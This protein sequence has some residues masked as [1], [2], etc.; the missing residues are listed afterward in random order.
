MSLN[1]NPSVVIDGLVMYYDMSNTQKSWKGA[2]TTNLA[3]AYAGFGSG[4]ETQPAVFNG[5]PIYRNT[6]TTPSVG[7]NFGFTQQTSVALN[8]SGPKYITLSFWVNVL[9]S[10][11]AMGGYADIYYTDTTTESISWTYSPSTWSTAILGVWKQVTATITLNAAKTPQNIVRWYVYRDF[12][13][14]GQWDI[15]SVQVEQNSFVTPFVAGTR[16]TTQSIIDLTS[17]N[18][19]TATSLTYASDNT[20]SFNY[21]TPNY[22]T[23][24]LAT[25]F[26]KTAGTMNFWLYPTR[27][28]GGNGY[29]VNREDAT[30]NAVDWFWIGPYSD[31]FYFRIGNGSDCCSNDLSFGSV[32]TV[33]P[34]NTWINLCFTWKINGTSVIYKN[35]VVLTSRSIGNIPNTNP[36]S[37]GRIGLG[38]A[39]GPSYFDGKMPTIQIYN[40]PLTAEEVLRNFQAIR[41][42]YGI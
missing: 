16:S 40:R 12:A 21:D 22:I 28:N 41:A 8:Q 25:A 18:T 27:Y 19:L 34:T 29:F 26:N 42:R 3:T 37:N 13:A 33:I 20:F 35:G 23:V 39:N 24:P 4:W 30:S 38:H 10:P 7:N 14:A 6:V 17:A 36:A 11:G 15:S 5:Q 31:T 32:S 9:I 1:H 2:P